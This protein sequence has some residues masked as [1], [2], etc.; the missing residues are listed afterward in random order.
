MPLVNSKCVFMQIS[1]LPLSIDF[2]VDICHSIQSS[3]CGG[4][5]ATTTRLPQDYYQQVA[6]K[7][8]LSAGDP[9]YTVLVMTGPRNSL[10]TARKRSMMLC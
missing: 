1:R 10:W 9:F 3:L 5:A 7:Y 8:F 6:N 4:S 2:Y